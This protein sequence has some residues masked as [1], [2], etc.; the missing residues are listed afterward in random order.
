MHT[1]LATMLSLLF[2]PPSLLPSG[3]PWFVYVSFA[4]LLRGASG[5]GTS[6]RRGGG[7]TTGLVLFLLFLLVLFVLKEFRLLPL[8]SSTFSLGSVYVLVCE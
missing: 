4:S 5:R 2:I 8:S 1:S 7:E 3:V 6:E